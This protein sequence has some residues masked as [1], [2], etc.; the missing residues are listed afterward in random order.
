MLTLEWFTT[1]DNLENLTD[2]IGWNLPATRLI[3]LD[4]WCHLCLTTRYECICDSN[5]LTATKSIRYSGLFA[6]RNNTRNMYR[7]GQRMWCKKR[8]DISEIKDICMIR[9]CH[10]V[11]KDLKYCQLSKRIRNIGKV[12]SVQRL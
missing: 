7:D 4:I 3:F 5:F 8:M 9:S 10:L 2:I 6:F 11:G 1:H 12:F